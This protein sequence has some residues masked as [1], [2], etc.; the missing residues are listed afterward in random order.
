MALS[1]HV[2][3]KLDRIM[4][5]QCLLKPA[6]NEFL[7]CTNAEAM[8]HGAYIH[9]DEMLC[10]WIRSGSADGEKGMGGRNDTHTKRAENDANHDNSR[11]YN[12]WPSKKS[13]RANNNPVRMGH[14][15]DLVQY[16]AV[17]FTPSEQVLEICSKDVSEGGI[18]FYSEEEK[19]KIRG[20]NIIGCTDGQKFTRAIAYLFEIRYDVALSSEFN[21]SESPGAEAGVWI[22]E[23]RR[24]RRLDLAGSLLH[25]LSTCS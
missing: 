19:A 11:L 17:G 14:W 25:Q 5:H 24:P 7:M 13:V 15:E 20:T 22:E 6:G 12:L 3:R 10:E 23:E 2:K 9:Y 18:F 4:L 1:G 8:L 21:V 16:V